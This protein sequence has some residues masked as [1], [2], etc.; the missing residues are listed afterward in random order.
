MTLSGVPALKDRY[1][2]DDIG[3][4][5]RQGWWEDKVV[6]D[7]IDR[8]VDDR[9]NSLCVADEHTT[10]TYA[11]AR[12]RAWRLAEGLANLGVGLG[13]RV[14]VQMPNVADAVIACY[15]IGRLGAILVPRMPIFR[16]HE[17]GSAIDRVEAK[18]LIV[19]D[20]F[21]KFDYAEM[22]ME[23][24]SSCPTLDNVI[25]VG[26]N[27]PDRAVDFEALCRSDAY[28]GPGPGPNDVSII[29]FTSGTTSEPKGVV[30]TWNT[31]LAGAHALVANWRLKGDDV[32]FMPSTVMHNTGILGGIL[33]PL[34]SQGATMLQAVWEPHEGLELIDRY[35]CTWS[36]GATPFITMMTDA[37]DPSRHDISQFRMFACG[38][39]PIPGSVV[40]GAAE[41]LGCKVMAVLGQSEGAPFTMTRLEDSVDRVACSDGKD[42]YG[43]VVAILDDDGNELARGVEGEICARGPALMLGY[44]DDPERTEE[45]FTSDGWLRSGDLGRMDDDGYIRVTGRKKDI[46]IRGGLNITPS[47]VE[48]MLLEHPDV[49]DV[50]CVG[51]PD[52]VFGEKMCAFVVPAE[53]TTPTLENLAHFLRQRNIATQKLPERVELRTELPR[54][55]I[56]KVEK[57]KLRYEIVRLVESEVT[58]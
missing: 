49:V 43:T 28:D 4:F 34:I 17:V 47:E 24:L 55:V 57:F 40:R 27:I 6:A 12:D 10:Y 33:A 41:A 52:K 53:G 1:N 51:M 5:R 15:A 32:C 31:H 8:A 2:E 35:R 7:Y 36:I 16:A 25:V 37:Y 45:A 56:G 19:A 13:D 39:A 3:T 26:A 21:R 48:E 54:N 46:I 11:Q 30:H 58:P 9:P 20:E 50:S 14:V 22:G 38:G 44:L 23:L 42:G 18:A 29:L